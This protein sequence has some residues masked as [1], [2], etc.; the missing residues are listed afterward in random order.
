MQ[1]EKDAE[2]PSPAPM[3]RVE[4]TTMWKDGLQR[5]LDTMA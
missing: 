2:D 5:T 3:G 4:R 1:T